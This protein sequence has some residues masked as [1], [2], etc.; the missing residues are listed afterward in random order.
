MRQQVVVYECDSCHRTEQQP[1]GSSIKRGTHV[2]PKGWLHVEGRSDR[3]SA[4]ELDL[5]AECKKS[6]M[7]ITE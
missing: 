1:L 7:E 6:I 2:L 4:F 3:R 5:C